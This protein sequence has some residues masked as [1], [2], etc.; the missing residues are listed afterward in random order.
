[1]KR[2][3]AGVWLGILLG[4]VPQA[5]AQAGE[6]LDELV[7]PAAH[8]EILTVP[9]TYGRLVTVAVSSEVHH[10]YFEDKQGTIHIVLVGPKGAVQRARHRFQLLS[11]NVFTIERKAKE[12]QPDD[13]Y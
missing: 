12:D 13:T 11:Q 10:L 1:M 3:L 8:G 4:W 7:I 5:A 2:W 6:M 9:P